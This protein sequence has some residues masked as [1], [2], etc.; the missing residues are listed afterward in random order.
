MAEY[1]LGRL[2]F[3]WQGNW[4]TGF[5][6]TVDDVVYSY[7]KTYICVVSHTASATFDADLNAIPTRWNLMADGQTWSGTWANATYYGK[8]ALAKNG[9]SV[10]VANTS[11]TSVA[12]TLTITATNLTLSSGTATLAYAAQGSAPYVPGQTITL[13]GFSPTQTSGTVNTVNTTFTVLTCSTTQLTFA[14]TGT[15]TQVT[16]G[17][18]AGAGAF[19][20]DLSK[21]DVFSNSF[22]WSGA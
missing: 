16:A 17:T 6:Y 2:K 12:S 22:N 10:Y 3:V 8:G 9:S 15:Y 18:V 14:L 19:E 4:T 21:W 1:K 7:G 5:S 11:H 20:S 13:A